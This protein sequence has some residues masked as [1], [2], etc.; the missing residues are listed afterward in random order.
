MV[1]VVALVLVGAAWLSPGAAF[2][3]EGKEAW[4]KEEPPGWKQWSDRQKEEWRRGLDHARVAIR[5]HAKV[6]EEAA[7]RGVEMAARKGVPLTEAEEMAVMA[8]D[9]GLDP[10]DYDALA[11][12]TANSVK[13][14]LKGRDLAHAVQQEIGRLKAARTKPTVLKKE[15]KAAGKVEKAEAA[16]ERAREKK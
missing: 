5:E 7:L 2:A 12:S 10:A 14:G 3:Q 9:G 1:F 6:R 11:Q 4:Q 16:Q 8:L 15:E 13:E